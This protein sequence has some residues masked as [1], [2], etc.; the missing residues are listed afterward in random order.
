[1]YE[2]FTQ[3]IYKKIQIYIQLFQISTTLN[4]TLVRYRYGEHQF[5]CIKKQPLFIRLVFRRTAARQSGR[6]V[7]NSRG[8]QG[9]ASLSVVNI[10]LPTTKYTGQYNVTVQCETCILTISK[11]ANNTETFFFIYKLA[12][13]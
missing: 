13:Q 7:E 9:E 3:Q 10:P 1:M 2:L 12:V 11:M 4:L 6:S 5:V 8:N